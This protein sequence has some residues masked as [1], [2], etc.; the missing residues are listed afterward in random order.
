MRENTEL[1]LQIEELES[2]E[3]PSFFGSVAHAFV[4]FEHAFING[5]LAI[6]HQPPINWS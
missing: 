3:A 1:S 6:V 4:G 5:A 2:I